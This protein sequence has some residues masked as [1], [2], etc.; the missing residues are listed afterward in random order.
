MFYV[1][2]TDQYFAGSFDYVF[3]TDEIMHKAEY[4]LS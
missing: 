4:P 1:G 3:F 2:F